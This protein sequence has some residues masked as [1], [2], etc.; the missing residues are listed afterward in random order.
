MPRGSA[1]RWGTA[2]SI[3]RRLS[4]TRTARSRDWRGFIRRIWRVP[5]ATLFEDRAVMRDAHHVHL[6]KANKTLSAKSILI[7]TGGQPY[8]PD[9]IEGR[10][11]AITSNEAFHLAAL[12]KSVMV[13]GGGYIAIEFAGIFNGLGSKTLLVHH[14]EE[15]LR[16]FDREIRERMR[17]EMQKRAI[18]VHLKSS[19]VSIKLEGG[20]KRVRLNDHTEHVVDEV[21]F[22]VGRRPNVEGLGLERAASRS[23]TRAQSRWTPIRARR[24]RTSM[25]SAT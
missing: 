6:V 13:V 12:P 5:G 18:D 8:V 3:G 2:I 20:R 22:A 7:A 11:H 15:V 25:R 17:H 9:G 24:A 14:G 10:E 4:R 21:M 16:G 23:T 19:V 1:G